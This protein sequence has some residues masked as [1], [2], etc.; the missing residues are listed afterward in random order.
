MDRPKQIVAPTGAQPAPQ[1]ERRV[2]KIALLPP[3]EPLK[4][5]RSRRCAH[6]AARLE[7][8][9]R[10]SGVTLRDES[11]DFRDRRE[12]RDP[13]AALT[14]YAINAAIMVFAF[15]V[16]FALLVFN[17]LGGENLRTTAHVMGLTG[18]AS[19]LPYL[20]CTVPFLS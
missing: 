18:L 2:R 11:T 5:R 12:S 15:P 17:I 16:G 20:G 6:G 3:L 7:Q 10:S 9:F 1:G 4:E 19:A 8:A 14:V 13:V